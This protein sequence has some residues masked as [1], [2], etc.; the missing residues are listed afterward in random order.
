MSPKPAIITTLKNTSMRLADLADKSTS[1]MKR[2]NIINV[3]PRRVSPDVGATEAQ[4][5][6][7]CISSNMVK[8]KESVI[9][10]KNSA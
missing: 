7:A 8:F 5:A 2:S 10:S 9:G 3:D 1:R 6:I 4:Q